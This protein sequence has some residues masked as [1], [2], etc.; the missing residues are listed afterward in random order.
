MIRNIIHSLLLTA[1]LT[2]IG[3]LDAHA[4]IVTL[5]VDEGQQ[6]TSGIIAAER[7]LAVILTE[8]NRSEAANSELQN[9]K[10][11][12]DDF[13]RKSLAR[14]WGVAHFKCDDEE[15][16]ERCWIFK[17]GSMMVRSIPLIIT[18]TENSSQM[19]E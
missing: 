13:A 18:Q 15:V 9:G 3:T 1:L 10:L 5:T 14:L 12:M 7:N 4:V 17:D 6:R 11:K 8:I 16:V 19:N 2:G